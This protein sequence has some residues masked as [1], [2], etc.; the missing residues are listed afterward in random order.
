MRA[1]SGTGPPRGKRA[2][3]IGISSTVFRVKK[4]PHTHLDE[5]RGEE[6][7]VDVVLF[8]QSLD[9]GLVQGSGFRVQGLG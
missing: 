8:I 2:P 7:E 4:S 6:A 5:G 9:R 3:R 1:G